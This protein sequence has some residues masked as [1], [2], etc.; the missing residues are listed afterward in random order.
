VESP[1]DPRNALAR[2]LR[3]LRERGWPG[4]KI[5]QGQLAQAL[6]ASEHASAPLISSWESLTNTALPSEARLADYATF[7]CTER[8]VA[9][10][11]YRLLDVA[12]LEPAERAR[13]DDLVRELI[14]LRNRS[15]RA[16]SSD[17]STTLV[18][19]LGG[20]WHFPDGEDV[21]IVCAE[22]PE[23]MRRGLPYFDPDDPDYVDLY[24]YAD[25]DALIELH[26]HIRAVNP[27][28]QVDFRTTAETTPDDYSKH[29][30]LL[31]G[32]DFNVVT[33]QIQ[34][35]AEFPVRQVA[36]IGA[37]DIG[38]FEVLNSEKQALYEPII[39]EESAGQRILLEDVAHFYRAPNPFNR[40]RTV[41]ICNGM[42][43][44]GVLGAVRALTDANFRGRNEGYL[45]HRFGDSDT[46]S[47]ITRVPVVNGVA[48]TPDWSIPGN[49]LH[50]WPERKG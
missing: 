16:P 24:R 43:G 1:D 18:D 48:V 14:E 22:L 50:E 20:F 19:V 23:D 30:V 29:L 27:T 45:R 12:E 31:G 13:R 2:K 28:V 17:F 10:R 7:F 15:A 5:T 49:L 25:P 11:P 33:A 44:R 35:R 42:F 47:I 3:W 9:S 46:L 4:R 37:T 8:S 34:H 21:V 41:T 26:G 32:V 36:R 39:Y 6:S 40:E 38:G